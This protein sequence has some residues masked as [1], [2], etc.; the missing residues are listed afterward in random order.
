MI[1]FIIR[2]FLEILSFAL[3]L[4]AIYMYI[5]LYFLAALIILKLLIKLTKLPLLDSLYTKLHRFS[6]KLIK[7]F[8]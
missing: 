2:T 1:A 6:P 7:R 3:A 5:C 4:L 8:F